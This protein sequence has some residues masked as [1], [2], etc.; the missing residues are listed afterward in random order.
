M[1]H[2]INSTVKVKCAVK[3]REQRTITYD[4]EHLEGFMEEGEEK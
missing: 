2:Y 1:Q 3:K 4:W